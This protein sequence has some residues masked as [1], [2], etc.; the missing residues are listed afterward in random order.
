LADYR[1]EY[2]LEPSLLAHSLGSGSGA[3]TPRLHHEGRVVGALISIFGREA[4]S[5]GLKRRN[6]PK[7]ASFP[8]SNWSQY[9]E[10]EIRGRFPIVPGTPQHGRSSGGATQSYGSVDI[11][12]GRR[13][14]R[15][16]GDDGRLA[17]VEQALEEII[18][19]IDRGEP[20]P[21]DVVNLA[22]ENFSRAVKRRDFLGAQNIFTALLKGHPDLPLLWNIELV[23]RL[24]CTIAVYVVERRMW[25]WDDM[26]P[27]FE[28]LRRHGRNA[29]AVEL[30][31]RL[32]DAL[33]ASETSQERRERLQQAVR[34]LDTDT[35]LRD[36]ER[37]LRAQG[38]TVSKDTISRIR[39][40]L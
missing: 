20:S 38:F 17:G 30:A 39:S 34:S 7:A 13:V 32:R 12:G 23:V 1:G 40:G 31:R 36:A 6:G 21:R 10:S 29:E 3:G 35:S 16:L 14:G 9:G 2:Q 25:P 26:P 27:I 8:E 18:D 15:R 11:T 24:R 5:E 28:W 33:D 37:L 19:E 22:F 4:V